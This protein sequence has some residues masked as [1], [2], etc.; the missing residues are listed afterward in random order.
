[1]N[2]QL[3]SKIISWQHMRWFAVPT[4]IG[5]LSNKSY[6]HWRAFRRE[7]GESYNVTEVNGYF[8]ETL[9]FN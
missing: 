9:C 5:P 1:M 8:V 6:L 4:A 3:K 2:V 7:L